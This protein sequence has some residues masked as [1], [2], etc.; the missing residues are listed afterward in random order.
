MLA[1][2][3]AGALQPG[4]DLSGALARVDQ[5]ALRTKHRQRLR[6]EVWDGVT[7]VNGIPAEV[8]LR[9]PGAERA[10]AAGCPMYHVWRDDALIMFQPHCPFT[11]GLLSSDPG[12]PMHVRHV[13]ER[14]LDHLAEQAADQEAL[15]EALRHLATSLGRAP[16]PPGSGGMPGA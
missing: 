16:R 14:H 5:T 1:L 3:R 4:L 7:P 12:H 2:G 10:R 11:G 13:A 9:T 6:Y 8:W 15:V